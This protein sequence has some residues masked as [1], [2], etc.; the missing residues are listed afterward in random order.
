MRN[1]IT[2]LEEWIDELKNDATVMISSY[3]EPQE[4]FVVELHG[5]RVIPFVEERLE[6]LKNHLNELKKEFEKL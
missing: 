5:T 4:K 2:Q 6:Y 3:K 1:E